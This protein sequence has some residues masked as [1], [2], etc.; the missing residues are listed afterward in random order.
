[1]QHRLPEPRVACAASPS[2]AL[3]GHL[4]RSGPPPSATYRT[5]PAACRN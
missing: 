5:W 2:F 3:A 4:H 1:M